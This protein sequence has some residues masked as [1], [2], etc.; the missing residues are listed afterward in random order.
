M[1]LMIAQHRSNPLCNP[2][3]VVQVTLQPV[4]PPELQTTSDKA[5]HLNVLLFFSIRESSWNCERVLESLTDLFKVRSAF[6]N[7]VLFLIVDAL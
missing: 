7:I 5:C 3:Q 6:S 4:L 1:I 2:R